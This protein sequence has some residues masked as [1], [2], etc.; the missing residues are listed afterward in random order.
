MTKLNSLYLF[1]EMFLSPIVRT[2]FL[3]LLQHIQI[4]HITDTNTIIGECFNIF[5]ALR[6]LLFL[7]EQSKFY[8]LVKHGF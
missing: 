3:N 6:F 8:N 4:T 7:Y 5:T 1:S 2:G